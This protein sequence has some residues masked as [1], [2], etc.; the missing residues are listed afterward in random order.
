MISSKTLPY[1][2]L[3]FQPFPPFLKSYLGLCEIRISQY[4]KPNTASCPKF[5]MSHVH[6]QIPFVFENDLAARVLGISGKSRSRWE[7][8]PHFPLE[9][10]QN[11]FVAKLE[12][13]S[14][15][16]LAMG[17]LP[18]PCPKDASLSKQIPRFSGTVLGV[19]PIKKYFEKVQENN[20][21]RTPIAV[22]FCR[23]EIRQLRGPSISGSESMRFFK[24][25]SDLL[26]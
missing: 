19:V 15:P 23:R 26:I 25:L 5:P 22:Y 14:N 7:L 10:F 4:P 21:G 6:F 1:R 12:S 8:S 20:V 9:L 18:S 24:N 17:Q 13:D 3:N 16:V 2:D 11:N